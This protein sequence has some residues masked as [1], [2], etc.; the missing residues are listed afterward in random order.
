MTTPDTFASLDDHSWLKRR[1]TPAEDTV[2]YRV[3]FS[4]ERTPDLARAEQ[5]AVAIAGQLL[6][7]TQAYIWQK[8]PFRLVAKQGA[9]IL[10]G[11]GVQYGLRAK[12]AMQWTDSDE[13]GCYLA[14]TTIFGDCIDD[15][16][17]IVFLLREISRSYDDAVI[18]WACHT[19]ARFPPSTCVPVTVR[20]TRTLYAQLVRQ[21]FHPP[22]PFRLP[23]PTSPDFKAA[24][25][26]MKLAC[27]FEILCAMGNLAAHNDADP[28]NDPMDVEHYPFAQDP[29]WIQ[30]SSQLKE[31][32]YYQEEIEGSAQYQAL[33]RKAREYYIKHK[34]QM[35]TS[36]TAMAW[37][38]ARMHALWSLPVASDELRQSM[39]RD[40][41]EDDDRWLDVDPSALDRMLNDEEQAFSKVDHM[42]SLGIMQMME[43]A[44][45]EGEEEEEEEEDAS[46]DD[47]EDEDGADGDELARIVHERELGIEDDMELARKKE[48][49]AANA[50]SSDVIQLDSAKFFEIAQSLFGD[51]SAT[52]TAP[53]AGTSKAKE[54]TAVGAPS[55][56][57]NEE[58]EEE[59][60]FE[61]A[62]H[63][64]DAELA[65][66]TLAKS[67]S[68]AV[69]IEVI[70]GGDDE[71]DEEAEVAED[72]VQEDEA[73]EQA[74][75]APL[76]ALD[77]DYNLVKNLLASF[78]INIDHR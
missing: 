28:V 36:E 30:F 72:A 41:H 54:P 62:M 45:A 18:Q 40:T 12:H 8:E 68:R 20:F 65:T 35:H 48:R 43:E 69:N 77:L 61:A 37:A 24:E 44:E 11:H 33:D 53:L 25:L 58:E 15:E 59:E 14:G 22:K 13:D 38:I 50:A 27:G 70:E 34:Q 76:E 56:P 67:F 47:D 63:A 55:M 66:T 23:P 52:T 7:H 21:P 74:P 51:I 17:F 19:M 1:P 32:G 49:V 16:W 2:A 26:G 29:Q 46:S 3:W 42:A 71:E 5:L 9:P 75:P 60:E 6:V 39:Q 31:T 4:R 64:M 57:S 73:V 78:D 10:L